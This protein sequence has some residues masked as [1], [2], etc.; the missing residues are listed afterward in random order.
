MFGNGRLFVGIDARGAIR[1]LFYPEVAMYS[2]L[3]G[4]AIRFGVWCQGDFVWLDEHQPA[5][6]LCDADGSGVAEWDLHDL[7]LRVNARFALGPEGHNALQAV[8]TANGSPVRLFATEDLRIRESDI[9]DTALFDPALN[10]VCHYKEDFWFLFRFSKPERPSY[11]TG[12]KGFAGLEGTW[13]D[14]EDGELSGNPI[15][16]GSVDATLGIAVEPGETVVFQIAAGRSYDEL[17]QVPK[18]VACTDLPPNPIIDRR[19][20]L[21]EQSLRVILAHTTERGA[22]VAANDSDIMATNRANYG[23]VWPRDAARVAGI[24]RRCGHQETARRQ[25]LFLAQ[26]MPESGWYFQKYHVDGTLGASWHPWVAP[27][28]TPRLPIQEDETA[29][30]VAEAAELALCE[31]E[32]RLTHLI[33]KGADFLASY[34][35]ERGLPLPSYDLWEERWAVHAYTTS[36]T[37]RALSLASE[38]FTGSDPESSSR[39]SGAAMAMRAAFRKHLIDPATGRPYRSL[40]EHGTPDPTPDASLLLVSRDL[41]ACTLV[42]LVS[43]LRGSLWVESVGGLARYPGDYYFRRTDAAPGNPWIICTLWL[44]QAYAEVGAWDEVDRLLEWTVRVAGP[45]M[46]LPEQIHAE[47]SE[48]LSVSPLVWSHAEYLETWG[49]YASWPRSKDALSGT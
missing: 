3:A 44:A 13:R 14:A 27:N 37:I 20:D 40:D 6:A 23:Y 7:G 38:L 1:D 33:R 26:I 17:L 29:T 24:L 12:I 4:H 8:F 5:M 49:R 11:A 10:G 46:V 36:E 15:A 22:M 16:Q 19:L 9:G 2:H 31:P 47:T 39:W 25:L 21:A 34:L 48:P 43:W 35:D 42:E 30:T 28:G 45:T 32:P 41:L 18:P